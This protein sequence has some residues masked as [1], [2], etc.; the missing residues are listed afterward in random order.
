MNLYANAAIGGQIEVLDAEKM[1]EVSGV[2]AHKTLRR[3]MR[4]SQHLPEPAKATKRPH[5]PIP[6][7]NVASEAANAEEGEAIQAETQG[8][9]KS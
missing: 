3:L 8:C 7:P 9:G 1:I 2:I 6:P 4:G 5:Q